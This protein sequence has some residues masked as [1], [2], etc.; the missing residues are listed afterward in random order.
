MFGKI[1]NIYTA[2]T[3]NE[4]L[5]AY[6]ETCYACTGHCKDCEHCRATRAVKQKVQTETIQQQLRNPAN[7]EQLML[8]LEL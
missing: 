4:M 5:K 7:R 6:N 3:V 2:E 1:G 8:A